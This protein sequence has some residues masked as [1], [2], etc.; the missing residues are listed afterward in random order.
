MQRFLQRCFR[1][2][3]SFILIDNT[4]KNTQLH[5]NYMLVVHESLRMHRLTCFKE[6]PYQTFSEKL[7]KL[8][9]KCAIMGNLSVQISN[10]KLM[11]R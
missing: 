2:V 5:Q 10:R 4:E 11:H 9:Q 8:R 3:V 7:G 1:K 6:F